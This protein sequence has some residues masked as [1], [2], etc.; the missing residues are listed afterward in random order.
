[1]SDYDARLSN[2]S[3]GFSSKDVRAGSKGET[4]VLNEMRP[5]VTPGR[6]VI[7]GTTFGYTSKKGRASAADID[8]A[9]VTGDRITIIDAKQW[10]SG[11]FA[12]RFLIGPVR[13]FPKPTRKDQRPKPIIYPSPAKGWPE[14]SA[15]APQ[16]KS[17]RKYL[18]DNGI[19]VTMADAFTVMT[20]PSS[21]FGLRMR[22]STSGT[23]YMTWKEFTKWASHPPKPGDE[24]ITRRIVDLMAAKGGRSL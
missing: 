17:L 14:V 12:R 24:H 15:L 22:N 21:S 20:N 5:A 10:R 1:M 18:S 2:E 9:V 6:A 19:E 8:I 23:R 7:H 3:T 16:W 13:L 11:K 4:K